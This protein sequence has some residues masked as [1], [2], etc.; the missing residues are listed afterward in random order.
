MR[1]P[2]QA[3]KSAFALLGP[4]RFVKGR[5]MG[6][7]GRPG[8]R[9]EARKHGMRGGRPVSMV[10]RAESW[11]KRRDPSEAMDNGKIETVVARG[12]GKAYGRVAALR[13]VSLEAVQGEVLGIEG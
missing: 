4:P 3:A 5:R 12:L 2:R 10:D 1:R 8:K 11:G 7:G 13:G 9:V 6:C